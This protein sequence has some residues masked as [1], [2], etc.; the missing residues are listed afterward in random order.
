MKN[1]I[2]AFFLFL[3]ILGFSQEYDTEFLPSI[4]MGGTSYVIG[5][6]KYGN[7]FLNLSPDNRLNQAP[8]DGLIRILNDSILIV[9]DNFKPDP[10]I[11]NFGPAVIKTDYEGRILLAGKG[12]IR[13]LEDGSVDTSFQSYQPAGINIFDFIVLKTN[14]IIGVARLA[15][16]TYTTFKLNEHGKVDASFSKVTPAD[17]SSIWI[18]E[19][20]QHILLGGRFDLFGITMNS[21]SIDQSGFLTSNFQTQGIPGIID[22]AFTKDNEFVFLEGDANTISLIDSTGTNI[23]KIKLKPNFPL[24]FNDYIYSF[25]PLGNDR[26]MAVGNNIYIIKTKPELSVVIEK[27]DVLGSSL[28]YPI[29][30]DSNSFVVIGNLNPQLDSIIGFAQFHVTDNEVIPDFSHHLRIS[31]SGEVL[32]LE[33]QK[34]GK[35]LVGGNLAYVNGISHRNILRLN[36]DGSLDQ[37]FSNLSRKIANPLIFGI[38]QLVNSYLAVASTYNSTAPNGFPNGASILTDKGLRIIALPF[39]YGNFTVTSI[40]FLEVS[41]DNIYAGQSVAVTLG[42]KTSQELVKFDRTGKFI[43]NYNDHFTALERYNG[44]LVQP[45]DEMILFGIGIGYDGSEPASIIKIDPSGNLDNSFKTNLPTKLRIQDVVKIADGYVV[46]GNLE[47]SE[48]TRF[49][50]YVAKIFESG[51]MDEDF[52]ANIENFT[53]GNLAMVPYGDDQFLIFGNFG[54]YNGEIINNNGIVINNRGDLISE[55]PIAF[56]P[57][58]RLHTYAVDKTNGDLYIGGKFTNNNTVTSLVR[59]KN[60]LTKTKDAGKVADTW[61][62]HENPVPVGKEL[63]IKISESLKD[64]VVRLYESGSGKMVFEKKF[65]GSLST[66]DLPIQQA[67]QFTITISSGNKVLSSQILSM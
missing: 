32:A 59:F 52:R 2:C 46:A 34:D 27:T 56:K 47:K 1:C 23:S 50:P 19:D 16:N 42:N 17:L 38:K 31:S 61:L 4:Q 14:E 29:S 24:A 44:F 58:D 9:D 67:G 53:S 7:V 8:Y 11:Q 21:I 10:I 5:N 36:N 12:V 40:T 43:S 37:Q 66:F 26:F 22:G 63:E 57:T 15:D 54:M 25:K 3:T 48:P 18:N 49:E 60:L 30:T 62:Q 65:S 35:I 55:S 6:D 45:N 51:L 64:P 20:T 28:A 39:P 13:L 41:T 33:V